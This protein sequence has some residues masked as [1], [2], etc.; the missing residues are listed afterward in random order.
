MTYSKIE[1]V[2][3]TEEIQHPSIREAMKFLDMHDLRLIYEADLPARTGLGTSSSFAVGMLS[4]F[5]ALKGKYVD[6]KRLAD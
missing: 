1:R 2:R 4:A 5:Y 6:K 3:D